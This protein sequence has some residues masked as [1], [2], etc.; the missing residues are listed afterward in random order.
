MA[1]TKTVL[2]L[3][4]RDAVVKVAGDAGSATI[5]LATDLL[6]ST[7]VINGVADVAISGIQWTGSA[8]ATIEI[9]RNGVTIMTLTGASIGFLEMQG[10]SMVP[11][12][13]ESDQDIIITTT[14]AAA[15]VWI[16]LKKVSGYL[17]KIETSVFSVY[18]DINA[19]GS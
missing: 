7:E 11:D 1:V 14:G 5:A 18:D 19:V 15:E 6:K 8:D 16:R 17:S 13:I 4:E 2:K 3:T 9:V 12:D 10:Q